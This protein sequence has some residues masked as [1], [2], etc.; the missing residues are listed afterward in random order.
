MLHLHIELWKKAGTNVMQFFVDLYYA[1]SVCV[2][3]GG[4]GMHVCVQ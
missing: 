4:G 2:C 1:F 3:G